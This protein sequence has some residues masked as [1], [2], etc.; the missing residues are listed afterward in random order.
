[1]FQATYFFHNEQEALE[2]TDTTKDI[3]EIYSNLMLGEYKD[4]PNFKEGGLPLVHLF[5]IVRTIVDSLEKSAFPEIKL[6]QLMAKFTLVTTSKCITTYQNSPDIFDYQCT[7]AIY[8]VMIAGSVWLCLPTQLRTSQILKILKK[9]SDTSPNYDS[10]FAKFEQSATSFAV[11]QE[12]VKAPYKLLRKTD[13]I[14]VM[15]ACYNLGFFGMSNPSGERMPAKNKDKFFQS[16]EVVFDDKLEN[17]AKIIGK[18]KQTES[19]MK[20]FNELIDQASKDYGA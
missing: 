3:A 1:M 7:D 12:G 16:L 9:C 8:R 20:V 13:F 11:K 19:Y 17:P 15:N 14:K 18:A 6:Q 4:F 10:L 2:W 5:N